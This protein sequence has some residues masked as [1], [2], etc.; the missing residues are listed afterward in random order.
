MMRRKLILLT[1]LVIFAGSAT[2]FGMKYV[3]LHKRKSALS[4]HK[5]T[6]DQLIKAVVKNH[7]EQIVDC[8]NQRLQD[9]LDREGQ[10]KISWDIDEQG[11]PLNFEEVQNQLRDSELYDCSSEAISQWQ[12]PKGIYFK[13]NY[14]FNLRQKKKTAERGIASPS[15]AVVE[16][17]E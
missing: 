17:S 2:V 7:M 1:V 12:F 3:K 10:L 9:G 15:M 14:T 8:Y 16:D 13:V 11:T 4:K 6:Q 5:P